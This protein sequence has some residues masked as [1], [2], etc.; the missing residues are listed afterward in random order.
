ME[1]FNIGKYV[2][3]SR[4]NNKPFRL[5]KIGGVLVSDNLTELSGVVRY[6]RPVFKDRVYIDRKIGV[7]LDN[8]ENITWFFMSNIK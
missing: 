3:L 1:K 8:E 7:L 6:N 2:T 5:V 4:I